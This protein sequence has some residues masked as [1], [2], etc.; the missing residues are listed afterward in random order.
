MRTRG[1]PIPPDAR[2]A[3]LAWT[4]GG[5][6]LNSLARE[7]G[8][9]PSSARTLRYRSR[10]QKTGRAKRGNEARRPDRCGVM[11]L[12]SPDDQFPV[13]NK[14]TMTD[15]EFMVELSGMVD[16]TAFEVTHRDGS[17]YQCEM[18]GGEL[19]KAN[20]SENDRKTSH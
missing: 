10:Q 19:V 11:V 6:S 15:L 8:V 2:A 16:G 17:V 13:G 1:K 14:F 18:R 20:V 3:I 12:C 5:I 4:P 9:I 7:L